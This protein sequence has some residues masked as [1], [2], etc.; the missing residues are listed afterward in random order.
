[1]SQASFVVIPL[2]LE[3]AADSSLPHSEEMRK[4]GRC[5]VCLADNRRGI[6]RLIAGLLC[7]LLAMVALFLFNLS[8]NMGAVAAN[9]LRGTLPMTAPWTHEDELHAMII[10]QAADDVTI[11]G[12]LIRNVVE[13]RGRIE[14]MQHAM[15]LFFSLREEKRRRNCTVTSAEIR[16]GYLP[17][18][19]FSIPLYANFTL[20]HA[21]HLISLQTVA[22]NASRPCACFVEY[23]LPH[24]AVVVP[25]L[26]A[27]LFCPVIESR[28]QATIS[29]DSSSI[30]LLQLADQIVP[31][32]T[33]GLITE[34]SKSA[35][36][37]FFDD[38]G[39][40]KRKVFGMPVFPCIDECVDLYDSLIASIK[41]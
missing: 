6:V 18:K 25:S 30:R 12:N 24:N 1:M 26:N 39:E 10:A 33:L 7:V 8:L 29:V 40:K 37:T 38:K 17:W 4:Y 5:G 23:G 22:G 27:T 28:S 9:G 41:Y 20:A 35:S 11:G 2:S 19:P 14:A 32:K 31:N 16:A 34:R 13:P 36:V 3:S 21:S 15:P